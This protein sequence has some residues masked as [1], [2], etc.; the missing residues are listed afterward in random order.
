MTTE[1][2]GEGEEEEG[3][4]RVNFPEKQE[5]EDREFSMNDV[6]LKCLQ[7]IRANVSENG[8]KYV[9]QEGG[10]GK[11]TVFERSADRKKRSYMRDPWGIIAF[12][13]WGKRKGK[14]SKEAE[15]QQHSLG[16]SHQGCPWESRR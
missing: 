8:D 3:S 14:A 5:W 1:W 13:I 9:I 12:N 7:D 10:Q 16:D 11:N 2:A 6:S 4:E 15:T